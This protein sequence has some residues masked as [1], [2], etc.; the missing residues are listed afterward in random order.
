MVHTVDEDLI[1]K[2]ADTC[3]R[4]YVEPPPVSDDEMYYMLNFHYNID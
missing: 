4:F 3:R 2:H 1:R